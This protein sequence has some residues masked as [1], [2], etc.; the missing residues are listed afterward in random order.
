[1]LDP[2]RRVHCSVNRTGTAGVSRTRIA[3][4]APLPRA[5]AHRH[6]RIGMR[7]CRRN[8]RC[9]LTPPALRTV[10]TIIVVIINASLTP[11]ACISIVHA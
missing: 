11:P 5:D 7:R 9:V 2:R 6:A 1:M 10:D 4:V 8:H 3:I